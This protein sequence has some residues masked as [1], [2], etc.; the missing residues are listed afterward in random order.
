MKRFSSLLLL[1]LISTISFSQVH[2]PSDPSLCPEAKNIIFSYDSDLW[3]VPVSGGTAL[4][5]TG[6]DGNETNPLY[7]PDGKWIAFTGTQDGNLNIYVMPSEGGKIVQLT[8]HSANDIVDSWTW[9]SKYIYFTSNRYNSGTTYKVPIHGGTPVRLFENYFGWSHNLIEHP[10]SGDLFFNDSWE[11]S[12]FAN[13]K[14]YKGDFN[15]DIKSY[16]PQTDEYKIHTTYIGKDMW[17]T[18]DKDGNLYF[19]SDEANNEYNLYKIESGNKKQLTNFDTSI[20]RPRVSYNGEKIVF[21]KDYQIF[22]YDV[23]TGTSYLPLI[24]IFDNSAITLDQEFNVKDK[25]SN[26]NASPDG[27]KFVFV[28]RG[29]M[30]VSDIEGKFIKKINTDPGERVIEA[31]WLKN[32]TT[33]L[34]NRTVKGW[35]NLFTVNITGEQKEKQITF[36]EMNNRE[37]NLNDDRTM[38]LYFSGRNELRLIDLATL[39]SETNVKDEFWAIYDAPARFSPDNKFIAFTAYRNFEQDIFIYDIDKKKL[40]NISN[41]GVTETNPF[42]SPDGKYIYFETDRLSPSYPR[43]VQ[44]SDVYRIALQKYDK[45]FRSD[46]LGKLFTEDK[47]DTTRPKVII[48]FQDMKDRWEAIAF[49]PGNQR[50]PFVIQK[51]DQTTLLFVSNHNG[52][53]NILWQTT[54]KPFDKTETKIIEGTKSGSVF[55]SKSK[56]DYYLLAEGKIQKLD[57]AT[58]KLKAVET[59][60]AFTKNLAS[61]F[62]QMFYETWA[63][64]EENYY[65]ENFHGVDWHKVKKQYE[66][67]LPGIRTREHLR[68]LLSDMLGELNSSH[69]GFNSTGEEEKVF[70]KNNTIGTGIIFK[71]EDP[72]R[73]GRIVKRSPADKVDKNI[74]PGDLLIA[75]NGVSV[76]NSINREKYFVAP[77]LTEEI[78]L[79]FERGK[80]KYNIKIHPVSSSSISGL[81]YDEWVEGNQKYVDEK[82]NKRIA[83]V[84][85]KNM[86]VGELNNFIIEMTDELHYRDALILDLRYNTGGNV[87]DDVL[88]FLSQR[89]YLQ[90]KYRGGQLTQ[91]PNF[92]P[93]VKPIVVL[94]NE[95]SLSDA[96]MTTAGFKELKLG[97]VIGTETYRW[98]IFT[99]GKS[100]VDGSFYRLPSWGCYTFSGDDLEMTGV[101]PDIYIKNT[102]KDKITGK[103]PQLDKALEEITK[104]LK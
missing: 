103:D 52:E 56:N 102:F 31:L 93:A 8:F 49:Q 94:V 1:F 78:E 38:G 29:V 90:W 42:W 95:Q 60:F 91:Q 11:S 4:R 85:M 32:N 48:D 39:K 14:R 63:N 10:K 36:D 3:M 81:L 7:S 58:S 46:R 33:I 27:K 92:T 66:N 87:H 98:I 57:L 21:I 69:L 16:N 84:H 104:Q 43:G 5:L 15:P 22:C 2:F 30:F 76:D 83:Y 67:Y 96:E 59:S 68:L 55:I 64:L 37:I 19:V 44:N 65:D 71:N 50:S 18:I 35:L 99:S 77:S 47:K 79:V 41:T 51:D 88:K 82:A 61:E 9:D 54:S 73:V 62:P 34:Y 20:K 12:I 86:G 13:R 53:N 24:K 89:P 40:T 6:M 100:L 74:L 80:E 75:V 28:S 23:K 97:K 17:P 70:Y 26:F 25:I 45:D 72:F 101:K